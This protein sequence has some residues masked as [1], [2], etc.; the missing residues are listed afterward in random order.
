VVGSKFSYTSSH[1]FRR[2]INSISSGSS[3]WLIPH[4]LFSNSAINL[5]SAFSASLLFVHFVVIHLG[6]V[7]LIMGS[8]MFKT[9]CQYLLL[10]VFCIDPVIHNVLSPF[11]TWLLFYHSIQ[12]ESN[13]GFMLKNSCFNGGFA[14]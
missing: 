10:L 4:A 2:L 9:A 8:G 14:V 1:C 13:T 12:T 3:S 11:Q 6:F 7:F 5:R